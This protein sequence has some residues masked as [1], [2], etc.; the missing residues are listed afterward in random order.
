MKS[1]SISGE[2]ILFIGIFLTPFTSLRFGIVGLGELLILSAVLIG[3]LNAGMAI[4]LDKRMKIFY[5]FWIAFLAVSIIG[6]YFN[7]FFAVSVSGTFES[8]VFDLFSYIFIL[9][10][11]FVIGHYASNKPNFSQT[12]FRKLFI[13]WGFAYVNLFFISL[14]FD[15]ILGLPLRY[16]GYFSPLVDNVHQASMITSSMSFIMFYLGLKSPET[17][18]KGLF[19]FAAGLFAVMAITSGSTKAMLGVVVG[20]L[21]SIIHLF[22]YRPTGKGRLYINMFTFFITMAFTLVFIYLYSDELIFLA[23]EFFTE[24]DGRGARQTIYKEGFT[25]AMNSPVV[26]LGPG[27]HVPYKGG[28]WDAHNS[29]LTI[30][31]Q[32]GLIGV[33]LF[34]WFNIKM[35][36]KLS[37]NF[38]LFGAIAAVGMY[39]IGG[40]ILRRLPM[41]IILMGIY[42]FAIYQKFYTSNLSIKNGKPR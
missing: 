36:S 11:I 29:T 39:I 28:F 30:F 21:V 7:N 20:A 3:I 38:A 14:Y 18:T 33:L 40:D 41:W 34:V 22:G 4:R 15:S 31:L 35:L 42:Y 5:N 1:L 24:N 10:T 2:K 19:F 9:I 13:Y 27:A 23:I 37:I 6:L 16:E 17:F 8:M 26:G 25:N 12:F 32:A